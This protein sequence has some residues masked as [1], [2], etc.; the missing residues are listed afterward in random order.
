MKRVHGYDSEAEGRHGP[1]RKHKNKSGS[2]PMKRSGSARSLPY[3]KQRPD[4]NPH[5]AQMMYP[6]VEYPMPMILDQNYMFNPHA[7]Y[8]TGQDF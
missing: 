3:P 2:A 6:P 8:Y 4:V 5:H 1:V 7:V